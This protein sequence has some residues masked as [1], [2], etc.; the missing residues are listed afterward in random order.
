M[1][2]WWRSPAK[3]NLV[4]LNY[5]D[6]LNLRKLK[7]RQ[8]LYCYVFRNINKSNFVL[9]MDPI[10]VLGGKIND[11]TKSLLALPKYTVL[12]KSLCKSVVMTVAVLTFKVKHST[13]IIKCSNFWYVPSIR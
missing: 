13:A 4:H 6:L 2:T 3:T 12:E 8:V 11:I 1:R 10:C 5:P 9:D 7:D